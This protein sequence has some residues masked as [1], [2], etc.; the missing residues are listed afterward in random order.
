MAA[1]TEALVAA[2]D[3]SQ[4]HGRVRYGWFID[5]TRYDFG[6]GT[7][8]VHSELLAIQR[9]LTFVPSDQPL[10]I[11]CDS[12]EAHLRLVDRI[13]PGPNNAYREHWEQVMEQVAARPVSLGERLI[14]GHRTD[15][16]HA[17]AHYLAF[18][19]RQGHRPVPGHSAP[20]A[21]RILAASDPARM[22]HLMVAEH[23]LGH[24]PLDPSTPNG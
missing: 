16:L 8:P 17:V 10:L 7:P 3:G 13:P 24:V 21:D 19:G 6:P 2:T 15:P 12:H 4:H 18:L 20:G 23:V 14:K 11:V 22:A 9:L 1:S 5:E